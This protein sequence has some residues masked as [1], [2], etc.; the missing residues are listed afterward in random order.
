MARQAARVFTLLASGEVQSCRPLCVCLLVCPCRSP[1][2][3]GHRSR[4]VLRSNNRNTHQ[5]AAHGERQQAVLP[6]CTP[7]RLR[8]GPYT[9]WCERSHS[10]ECVA[11]TLIRSEPTTKF[12]LLVLVSI[13]SWG[14]GKRARI[15][16]RAAHA[17][18]TVGC[19]FTSTS[20]EGAR[21]REEDSA[22]LYGVDA[23]E[24]NSRGT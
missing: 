18:T 17:S 22:L 16:K 2:S 5:F 13:R 12:M 8:V 14:K 3:T 9:S 1:P 6:R 4:Y 15:E 23:P 11:P 20:E 7:T 24:P 19:A 21:G 10:R